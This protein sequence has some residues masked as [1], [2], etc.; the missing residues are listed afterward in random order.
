MPPQSISGS[1]PRSYRSDLRQEQA[2]LTR[3]RVVAA[4]GDLF[5]EQ[6][7]ARTTLTKI[8]DRAGVSPETVGGHGP[9]AA[10]LIAAIEVAAVGV[11]D[12]ENVL[13]LA[14]GQ[15]FLEMDDAREALD[16]LVGA[17]SDV[18]QRTAGLSRALIGG[19]NADPTLDR[20]WRD[21]VVSVTLQIRRVLVVCNERGWLRVDV[22]F[23]D[24]V[25]TAAIL[26]SIDAFIRMTQHDGWTMTRYESWLRRMLAETVFA[27][28][29]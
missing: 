28:A 6:G 20:Y 16:Y 10:L 24:V 1:A 7:Y 12:E 5:A 21:L 9:K 2:E 14:V 26:G 11:S 25:E 3:S 8:A 19:A 13:N 18:N 27:R 22:P 15:R 17:Q 4:A 29:N 23:D